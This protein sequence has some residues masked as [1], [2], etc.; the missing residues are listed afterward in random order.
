MESQQ[1][2]VLTIILTIG[3][4]LV[5]GCGNQQGSDPG[6]SMIERAD[7]ADTEKRREL[8]RERADTSMQAPAYKAVLTDSR[9]GADRDTTAKGS[10]MLSLHD[11]SIHIKGQFS[12][13]S[14]T[15]TG[16]AI[17]KVLESNKV[18]MLD[19]TLNNDKTS[20]SWE[21]SYRLA[22]DQV[23]ALKS[24]SLYIS[25]YTEEYESGEINGQITAVDSTDAATDSTKNNS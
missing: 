12:G 8:L 18:Q 11:D 24:D 25:V 6:T 16:S 1:V 23:N 17:H 9:H 5:T 21:A 14:S 2:I 19:P 7:T 13:L 3:A 20:G 15:Y 22:G 10:I 4:M